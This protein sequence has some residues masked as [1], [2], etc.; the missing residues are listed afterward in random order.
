MFE[1]LADCAVKSD[2]RRYA[3]EQQYETGQ[4]RRYPRNKD[5]CVRAAKNLE[6][7]NDDQD[8]RYRVNNVYDTHHEIVDASAEIAGNCSVRY[9]DGQRNDRRND[10][11]HQRDPSA[12]QYTCE[13]VASGLV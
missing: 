12:L 1:I 3:N 11:D 9:A 4:Y 5:R 6:Q 13:Q 10:A 7:D 2:R 8:I